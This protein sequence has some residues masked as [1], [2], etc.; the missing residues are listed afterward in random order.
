MWRASVL[1]LFPEMFPGPLGV[2]LAGKALASGMWELEARDIRSSATD[3][4]SVKMFSSMFPVSET[5]LRCFLIRM[6]PLSVQ[7]VVFRGTVSSSHCEDCGWELFFSF[8][9]ISISANRK[10][11]SSCH[12]TLSLPTRSVPYSRSLPNLEYC[13]LD[14]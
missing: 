14:S 13:K 6:D 4:L 2:S 7:R 8:T 12:E 1:T 10:H 5:S 9:Q 3:K 11:S